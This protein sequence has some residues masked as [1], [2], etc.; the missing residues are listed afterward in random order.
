M[1]SF[2]RLDATSHTFKFLTPAVT[3]RPPSPTDTEDGGGEYD[4]DDG[5]DD[6]DDNDDD[7]DDDNNNKNNNNNNNGVNNNN[8]NSNNQPPAFVDIGSGAAAVQYTLSPD[9]D[10]LQ[11]PRI[12]SHKRKRTQCYIYTLQNRHAAKRECRPDECEV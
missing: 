8:N 2:T 9:A 4:D 10:P 11:Y 5:E 7:D 12:M 3:K 6:G 1:P